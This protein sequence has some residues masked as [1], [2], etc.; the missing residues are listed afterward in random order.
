MTLQAR[1]LLALSLLALLA[2]AS[3]EARAATFCVDSSDDFVEALATAEDNGEDND[4]RLRTGLY[5]APDG[6]F[7]IDLLDGSHSLSVVGGY[8]NDA[9]TERTHGEMRVWTNERS[10]LEESPPPSST[11]ESA[12]NL[13][14]IAFRKQMRASE[15]SQTVVFSGAVRAWHGPAT[16]PLHAINYEKLPPGALTLTCQTLEIGQQPKLWMSAEGKA[17]IDGK[18][19]NVRTIFSSTWSGEGEMLLYRVRGNGFLHHMVR[20]L[21]GTFLDAGRGQIEPEDIR[22]ILEERSRSAAGATA[23][24]RGLF[25]DR[26]EY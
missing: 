24:A 19:G 2:F 17:N 1:Y 7:H 12:F 13:T 3:I 4:I 14:H 11:S 25:L 5:V 22:G 6:G 8:T 20:N 26:V 10:G 9:C 23:P 15:K 18:A 16:E 21:V